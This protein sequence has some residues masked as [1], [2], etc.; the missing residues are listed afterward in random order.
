MLFVH[1]HQVVGAR[2]HGCYVGAGTRQDALEESLLSQQEELR[3][4]QHFI[5]PIEVLDRRH[6]RD[7]GFEAEFPFVAFA[8]LRH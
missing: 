2:Q 3:T 5:G 7:T 4:M 1:V 8:G 6:E